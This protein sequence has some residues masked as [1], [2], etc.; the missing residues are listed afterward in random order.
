[1]NNLFETI[2]EWEIM[3]KSGTKTDYREAL[4]L[5]LRTFNV[6]VSVTIKSKKLYLS[7]ESM[8]A[9][10]KSID[11]VNKAKD[12]KTILPKS[13]IDMARF[14]P[15]I[16]DILKNYEQYLVTRERKRLSKRAGSW[17]I[18]ITSWD[19][20][21]ISNQLKKTKKISA[22]S[23]NDD[24]FVKNAI[25]E[26][27]QL[28]ISKKASG[29]DMLEVTKKYTDLMI[30]IDTLEYRTLDR[31]VSLIQKIKDDEDQ[32]NDILTQIND[33][34]AQINSFDKNIEHKEEEREKLGDDW[35]NSELGI[36]IQQLSKE[37]EN[38][39]DEIT[40][41][42]KL[43][44]NL[45]H[46]FT[47][48]LDKQQKFIDIPIT[49]FAA[50][51]ED[52]FDPN[53]QIDQYFEQLVAFFE[54]NRNVYTTKKW[55]KSDIKGEK[56]AALLLHNEDKKKWENAREIEREISILKDSDSYK[57][58]INKIDEIK[59]FIE[60]QNKEKQDLISKSNSLNEIINEAN[61]RKEN[62]WIELKS[63]L[64]QK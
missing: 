63:N 39:R 8:E 59:E 9:I 64:S 52:I 19:E 34:T 7:N 49:V 37:K 23:I 21:K 26:L 18:Q 40:K 50:L 16:K 51:E 10:D 30:S 61:S 44:G 27:K 12:D 11:L 43:F 33:S 6:Y 36:K 60:I 42:I 55:Y 25:N 35:L 14:G 38:I 31:I 29:K 48:Y 2:F 62:T 47:G 46:V 20:R 5:I 24:K 3:S 58:Y 45:I 28:I 53:P 32:I 56:L 15:E 13:I 54:E 41:Y 22:K 17:N 57:D 4:E 1:M